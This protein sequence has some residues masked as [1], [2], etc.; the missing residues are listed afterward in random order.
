MRTIAFFRYINPEANIRLG[1]GRDILGDHGAK[2]FCSGASATITG[3][4]LTTSGTTIK[5]DHELIASLG[6]SSEGANDWD[7]EESRRLY[8]ESLKAPQQE[9]VL[10]EF[11]D[12]AVCQQVNVVSTLATRGTTGSFGE[13]DA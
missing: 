8:E 11:V 6:M 4:M 10:P 13:K 5:S 7:D 9:I 3:D 12:G 2:A 1:A